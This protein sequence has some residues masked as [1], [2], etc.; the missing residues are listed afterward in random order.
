M[1]TCNR[2]GV[3][4]AK[5]ERKRQLKSQGTRKI[6]YHCTSCIIVR[7]YGTHVTADYYSK[8]YNHDALLCHIPIPNAEKQII[9]GWYLETFSFLKTDKNCHYY[10]QSYCSIKC[11]AFYRSNN[12]MLP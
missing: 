9:A 8:H 4:K 5:D 1:F 3:F 7:D 11:T 10:S 2:S 12:V 6:G